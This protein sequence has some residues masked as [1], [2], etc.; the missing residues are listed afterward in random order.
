MPPK[1][2]FKKSSF[3]K[4]TKPKKEQSINLNAKY[5]IIVESPSK[6]SKIEGFLGNEYCC[7]ASKGHIRTIEGLKSIDT[8][9]TFEPTFSI[10]D[11][12]KGQVEFMRSIISRFSKPKVPDTWRLGATRCASE[13]PATRPWPPR[14]A[15]RFTST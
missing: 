3:P 11:E 15:A 7:I 5:L 4:S 1:K 6:C 12:K 10:I 13:S 14:A 8:K 9:N 2:F